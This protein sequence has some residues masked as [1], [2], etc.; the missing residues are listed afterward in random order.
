M[1]LLVFQH[2]GAENPGSLGTFLNQDG[3]AWDTIE[4]DA[5]EAIPPFERFSEYAALWVM[6]GPMDTWQEAA[7]PWLIAE[8]AAIR[9]WVQVLNKP[10]LGICLGHQLLAAA[11][12]GEVKPMP[13]SEVGIHTVDLTPEGQA[14]PLFMG[15]AAQQTCLQ[16]HGAQVTQLPA[17]STILARSAACAIQAFRVGFAAYGLQYHVELTDSTVADWGQI[18]AYRQSLECVI[19][20]NAQSQLEQQ[21]ALHLPVLHASAKQLYANFMALTKEVA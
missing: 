17:G 3:I 2:I 13:G 21:A 10:F 4:L 15:M 1:K 12:G 20:P 6:G 18:P 19:G 11:L 8:K 5:G 14:D 16:W 7:Y 9:H